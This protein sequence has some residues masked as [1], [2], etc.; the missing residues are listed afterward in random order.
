MSIEY[1]VYVHRGD[2]RHVHGITL[3]D[4]PGCFSVADRWEDISAI[5]QEAVEVHCQDASLPLPSPSALAD[6]QALPEHQ[7]GEW[8]LVSV[9]LA[10]P[11][12]LA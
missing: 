10:Q 6:L 12:E 5:V 3:P 7:G 11:E 8:P 4:F 1:P 2:E 9:T